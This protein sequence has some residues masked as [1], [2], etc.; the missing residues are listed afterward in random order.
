MLG[1]D[2]TQNR[3]RYGQFMLDG[4]PRKAHRVS[5]ML[6]Y[7]DVPAGQHALHKCDNPPCVNP[8]HLF[9][10]SHADNMRDKMRKGRHVA[11]KGSANGSAKLSERDVFEIRRRYAFGETYTVLGREFGVSRMQVS[12]I[13]SR[14]LWRHL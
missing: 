4:K 6:T 11:S 7:G 10:G 8:H 2:C 9:L 14:E 5:W 3:R 1:V 12:R 13:V